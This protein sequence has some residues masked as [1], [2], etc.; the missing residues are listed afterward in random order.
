MTRSRHE[1]LLK[2]QGRESLIFQTY[3]TFSIDF[4]NTYNL[5]A[6]V[7][8]SFLL[9]IL[10]NESDFSRPALMRFSPLLFLFFWILFLTKHDKIMS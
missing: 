3:K 10:V 4:P 8:V 5:L 6:N 7:I 1:S 2:V 9:S